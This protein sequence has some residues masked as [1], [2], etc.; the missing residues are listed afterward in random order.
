MARRN[1][2]ALAVALFGLRLRRFD[3]VGEA[4]ADVV[5]DGNKS[6]CTSLRNVFSIDGRCTPREVLRFLLLVGEDGG[7]KWVGFSRNFGLV[8]SIGR[9]SRSSTSSG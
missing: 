9:P 3:L 4:G 7:I 6:R 8:G 5:G 1:S 2:K